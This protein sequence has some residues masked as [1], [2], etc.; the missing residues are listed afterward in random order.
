MAPGAGT[1]SIFRLV[2]GMGLRLRGIG[3]FIGIALSLGLSGI[4]AN[5]LWHV[6]PYDPITL[7]TVVAIVAMVGLAA[8]YFP[9]RW[10]TRVNPVVALR[11]EQPLVVRHIAQSC[12]FI[13]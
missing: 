12:L 9:A 11:Y 6:S 7:C 4:L 1:P 3:A 2:L 10:A 8:C 5:Q 13:R